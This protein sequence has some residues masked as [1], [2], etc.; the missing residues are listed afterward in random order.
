[1]IRALQIQ[2]A[3]QWFE[4]ASVLCHFV[5]DGPREKV[6]SSVGHDHL[7]AFEN[8]LKLRIKTFWH[9]MAVLEAYSIVVFLLLAC[10]YQYSV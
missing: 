6:S 3:Q 4:V 10:L 1:L 9:A 7:T 8:R 5:A 2:D